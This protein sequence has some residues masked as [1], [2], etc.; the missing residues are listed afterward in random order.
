MT[1]SI[2][3]RIFLTLIQAPLAFIFLA[4]AT[5]K[6]AQSKARL[7]KDAPWAQAYSA[8]QLKLLGLAELSA[9]Y[10]LVLP[11]V[12]NVLPL[13]APLA[14]L[15]MFMLMLGATRLH[16]RRREWRWVGL[17]GVLLSLLAGVLITYVRV[18]F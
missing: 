2:S 7:T 17:T 13:L 4:S 10:G 5:T 9:S 16:L 12:M 11:T 1:I 15:G 8:R 6:L 18:V 3:T 14:A